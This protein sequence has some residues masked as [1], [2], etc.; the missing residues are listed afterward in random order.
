MTRETYDVAILGAGPTGLFGAFYA[1]MR[2]MKTL[3]L[4]SLE[5]LG[6]QLMTLYPEKYV[7]DVGGFPKILAK[8][9]ATGLV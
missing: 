2:H 9:L 6:G 8:D 3:I 4:D 7:Y 5:E 1:G